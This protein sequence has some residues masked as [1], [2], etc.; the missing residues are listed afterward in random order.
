MRKHLGLGITD[1]RDVLGLAGEIRD[2]QLHPRARVQLMDLPDRFGVQPHT[3]IGQVITGHPGHR[4]VAQLHRLHAAGH[5]G[6]FEHVHR[7]GFA[8]ID[9]AEITAPGALGPAD[10]ERR[11]LVFPALKNVRAA[12]LFTHRVQAF[13]LH[14]VLELD[15]LRPH[16]DLGL[17]PLGLTFNRDR[18]V[19]LLNAQQLTAFRC[20]G[21]EFLPCWY[22]IFA[23]AP[24]VSIRRR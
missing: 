24:A 17:D 12:G 2:Q 13:L 3:L 20:E 23:G 22:S 19:T 9:L 5:L 1:R 6:G 7:G 10:Q 4:G 16:L 8:G 21:H 15:E 11:F 18:R 14:Q